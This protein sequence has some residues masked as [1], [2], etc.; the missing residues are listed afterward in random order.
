VSGAEGFLVMTEDRARSL[1]LPYALIAGAVERH[2]GY[3]GDTVISHF[4]VAAECDDLYRQ[5]S[6]GPDAMAFVEAYDDYP[7]MVMLELEA[8]GFSR[9][10]EAVSL[11]REKDLTL[12]GD[13]AVNT[14][15]G[16]LSLGQAG[17]GAGF[18]HINEAIGQLT[19][20]P[21]GRAVSSPEYG[22]VTC[23]GTVNYDRGICTGAVILRKGGAA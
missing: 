18:L 12:D 14:S 3:A 4:G 8:L 10:G 6:V 23:L 19:G 22:L 13:I 11:V 21:M 15:G 2:N 7:V 9:P 1:R 17:A 5:A 20:R 16:M